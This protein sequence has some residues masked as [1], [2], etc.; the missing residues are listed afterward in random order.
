LIKSLFIFILSIPL[1]FLSGC[2][3]TPPIQFQDY[4]PDDMQWLTDEADQSG[5]TLRLTGIHALERNIVFLYG[6]LITEPGTLRSVLLRS[7]D[8]GRYWKEVMQPEAGSEITELVFIENEIGWAVALWMV[9][10]PGRAYLYHTE[11]AGA[12]WQQVS[13]FPMYDLGGHSFPSGLQFSNAQQG[14]IRILSVLNMDC[15]RYE[16]EDGGLTWHKTDDCLSE[17]ECLLETPSECSLEKM[18]WKYGISQPDSAIKISRRLSLDESWTEV[19]KI[20]LHYG[21]SQGKIVLP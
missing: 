16:T 4:Q 13:E 6:G 20:P 14:T 9:E 8:G 12:H 7:T 3:R 17:E 5:V 2:G 11:D 21:Y 1:F 15:C 10:G 18:S 19:S